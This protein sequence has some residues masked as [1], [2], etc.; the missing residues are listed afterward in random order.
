MMNDFVGCDKLLF[1]T[2]FPAVGKEMVEWYTERLVEQ[3]PISTSTG[4]E[5][6]EKGK[7]VDEELEKIMVGNAR[8]LFPRLFESFES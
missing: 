5:E 8:K 4:S 6:E 1:G 2:D 3:F 7:E